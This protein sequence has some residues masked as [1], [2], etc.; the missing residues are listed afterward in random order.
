[1]NTLEQIKRMVNGSAALIVNGWAMTTW[2]C[3]DEGFRG[4]YWNNYQN[5]DGTLEFSIDDLLTATVWR[6]TITIPKDEKIS[7]I[8][9][10]SLVPYNGR[11][12]TL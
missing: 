12:I 9:C 6:N 11:K 7:T 5:V 10:F 2:N 8:E 4:K 1:M 3:N